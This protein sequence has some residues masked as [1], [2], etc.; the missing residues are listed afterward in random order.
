MR[1][2]FG[3]GAKRRGGAE[4]PPIRSAATEPCGSPLLLLFF[5]RTLLR[6]RLSMLLWLG[7][8]LRLRRSSSRLLLWLGMLLRLRRSSSRLLL[9]L[10]MLL[11]LR[12]SS[13]RLLLWLGMLL[14][15]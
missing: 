10:G 9:W 8:L 11:R 14:R 3:S 4:A 2:D 12:R 13:S 5:G 15:L 6:L 1:L 7:M